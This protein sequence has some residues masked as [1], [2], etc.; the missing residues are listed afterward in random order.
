ML[1]VTRHDPKDFRQRRP[2]PDKPGEWIWSIGS[3]SGRPLYRLSEMLAADPAEPVLVVEGEKDVDRLRSLGF[4]VTTSSQGAGNWKYSDGSPLA[5]RNIVILPDND[6]SGRAYAAEV[7]SDLIGKAASVRLLELPVPVKGDVS[8]WL[9]VG[10]T[11]DVLRELP[12]AA[13]AY[14]PTA[15]EPESISHDALALAGGQEPHRPVEIRRPLGPLVLSGPAH[16]GNATISGWYGPWLAS[17]CATWP[18]AST[19]RSRPSCARPTP[20]LLSSTS[21]AATS[22]SQPEFAT[23]TATGC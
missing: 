1:Q 17:S 8:D 14:E 23:G 7:G 12:A 20:S 21:P 9:D 22:S 16:T 6:A 2:D 4:A 5:G 10:G 13:P 19:R 15:A 18:G 3:I 11:A